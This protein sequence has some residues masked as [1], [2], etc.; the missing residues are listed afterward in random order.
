MT[1]IDDLIAEAKAEEKTEKAVQAVK[2]E[3]MPPFETEMVN[4]PQ[5]RFE[6]MILKSHELALLKRLIRNCSE[7]EK[8]EIDGDEI[9][10]LTINSNAFISGLSSILPDFYS[11]LVG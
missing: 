5:Y 2:L 7:I 11:A 3:P 9:P 4:I 6:D 8:T 1:T 10:M